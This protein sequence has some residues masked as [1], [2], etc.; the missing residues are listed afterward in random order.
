MAKC[1]N[2][3]AEHRQM[4]TVV[5]TEGTFPV[6]RQRKRLSGSVLLFH[7]IMLDIQP[8]SHINNHRRPGARP[9]KD[10]ISHNGWLELK[11]VFSVGP[12]QLMT[13]QANYR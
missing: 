1:P 7:V 8:H 12:E 6:S 5:G 11:E 13:M 9:L 4:G 10:R 2:I 3:Q